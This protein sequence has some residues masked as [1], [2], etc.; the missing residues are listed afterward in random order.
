MRPQFHLPL[1]VHPETSSFSIIGN[2][3][4]FSLHQDADL[5]ASIPA[6]GRHGKTTGATNTDDELQQGELDRDIMAQLVRYLRECAARVSVDVRLAAGDVEPATSPLRLSELA[7]AYDLTILE[8]TP[9]ARPVIEGLFFESGRPVLLLP[10]DSFYGRIDTVAIAWD[11]SATAARAVANAYPAM[12]NASRA[13]LI[14]IRNA[15][16]ESDD[17][18]DHYLNTLRHAGLEA[19]LA[20]VH[21]DGDDAPTVIQD[22]ALEDH[23][24]LLIAGAY[25]HSRLREALFG[26]VTRGL[27]DNLCV[28]TLLSH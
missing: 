17:L 25:G 6:I 9:F 16:A 2:A 28:P 4:Q 11:G 3:V 27:L 7:R 23:A 5:V 14:R 20:S 22:L 15:A 13:I 18:L 19:I 8:N 12:K 26:G 1:S 10:Q 24:D 21:C